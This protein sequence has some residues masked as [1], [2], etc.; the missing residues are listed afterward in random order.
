VAQVALDAFKP[1]LI[2][3]HLRPT[4]VQ[5]RAVTLELAAYALVENS[6][7]YGCGRRF[8]FDPAQLEQ[9]IVI[10]R[11]LAPFEPNTVRMTYLPAETVYE[12]FD[13]IC[14]GLELSVQGSS[15]TLARGAT[16]I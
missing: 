5:A 7:V 12:N 1:S 9:R 4:P 16:G 11:V 3:K 10:E 13:R 15:D 14:A 8:I 2:Q 6:R